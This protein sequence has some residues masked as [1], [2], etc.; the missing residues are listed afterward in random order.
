L[1]SAIHSL[2]TVQFVVEQLR[3]QN[4]T[5]ESQYSSNHPDLLGCTVLHWFCH[6][7]VQAD[8]KAAKVIQWLFTLPVPP[9]IHARRAATHTT[10]IQEVFAY[11]DANTS[12][13]WRFICALVEA[14][15]DLFEPWPNLEDLQDHNSSTPDGIASCIP[16][17][18]KRS[19]RTYHDHVQVVLDLVRNEDASL[20]SAQAVASLRCACKRATKT[21][22]LLIAKQLGAEKVSH[23]LLQF[24]PLIELIVAYN[25]V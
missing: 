9:D 24:R 12:R 15:A 6:A 8:E 5:P 10:A 19:P 13:P 16:S 2:E 21:I 7:T 20:T 22:C 4:I 23:P 3:R 18:A 1:W 14:G 17:W 25:Y 11:G